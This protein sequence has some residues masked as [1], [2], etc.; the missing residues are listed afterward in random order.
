MKEQFSLDRSIGSSGRVS[1]HW[2]RARD[3][4]HTEI[5]VNNFFL[6]TWRVIKARK[7]YK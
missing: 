7:I 6:L 5:C 4:R 3:E 2:H 1:A